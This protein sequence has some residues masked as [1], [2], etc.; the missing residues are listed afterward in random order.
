MGTA[1]T[2]EQVAL[3]NM[4]IGHSIVEV[5]REGG[6][7]KTVPDSPINRRITLETRICHL[8]PLRRA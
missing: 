8:R 6:N 4:A 1:M 3:C 5:K 7:W 2:K